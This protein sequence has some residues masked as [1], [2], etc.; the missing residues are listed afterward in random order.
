MSHSGTL[1]PKIALYRGVLESTAVLC[2]VKWVMSSRQRTIRDACNLQTWW[3]IRS[4]GQPKARCWTRSPNFSAYK[5]NRSPPVRNPGQSRS[6]DRGESPGTDTVRRSACTRREPRRI[7][8]IW[9]NRAMRDSVGFVHRVRG[10]LQVAFAP[11]ILWRS[12]H[13]HNFECKTSVSRDRYKVVSIHYDI[14]I[15]YY[16][17]VLYEQYSK[18]KERISSNYFFAWLHHYFAL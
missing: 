14:H 16:E 2:H 11:T 3:T 15:Y 4:S 17:I 5:R 8:S 7:P 12:N 10:C 1:M 13:W 9:N 6:L 18:E